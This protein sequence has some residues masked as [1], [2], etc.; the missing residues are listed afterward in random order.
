MKKLG[1]WLLPLLLLVL[2]G[3]ATLNENECVTADWEM[4]GFE[5]GRKGANADRLQRH[6]E[7]CAKYS[8]TPDF[9]Q[10]QQGY[11]KGVVGF[12]TRR[13]GFERAKSGYQYQ[14]ICPISVEAN[15]LSGYNPGHEIYKLNQ[16]ISLLDSQLK[17]NAAEQ[18]RVNADILAIK[19]E[20][21]GST[22][23]A[24]LTELLLLLESNLTAI[25]DL[26]ALALQLQ[27]DRAEAQGAA[28]Q[29]QNSFVY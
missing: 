18:E 12:C 7:A 10:Y 17:T 19:T 11:E 21:L 15:F 13:N 16:K 6:R 4:I 26:E 25:A 5:D 8:I 22:T 23:P 2:S 24:R 14:G 3:C 1:W 28:N 29:L 20:L 27:L 9:S